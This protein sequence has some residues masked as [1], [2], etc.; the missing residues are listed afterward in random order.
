M[1]RNMKE[2]TD[3]EILRQL[4]EGNSLN[5]R[6]VTDPDIL[7]QL[8]DSPHRK[9]ISLKNSQFDPS[10][11]EKLSPN[12]V[13]GFATL[14]HQIVNS[15]HNISKYISEK[16]LLS[17]KIA[18]M[19]PKQQDY[20][21]SEMMGI[22]GTTADKIVQGS[23]EALPYML[24]P[25]ADLGIL[26]KGIE[27]IPKAGKFLSKSL[28][29]IIPQSN[30]GFALS[31]HP[32][33]GGIQAGLTQAALE[34][35]GLPFKAI[36]GLAQMAHPT[37]Y[38]NNLAKA[39]SENY[40]MAKQKASDL[41]TSVLDRHGDK[42]I[43]PEKSRIYIPGERE[44]ANV[45]QKE[46]DQFKY[47]DLPKKTINKYF[48]P[49]LKKLHDEFIANPSLNN[50]H[51]LQSHLFNEMN[52]LS[53]KPSGSF[54]NNVIQTYN[55]ARNVLNG[56][57]QRSLGRTNKDA[58]NMYNQAREITKNHVVPFRSNPVLN[59]VAKGTVQTIE[60]QR[61]NKALNMAIEKGAIPK[62]HYLNEASK[63]LSDKIAKGKLF[64]DVGSLATGATLGEMMVPGIGGGAAGA[65]MGKFLS[66]TALRITQN[67]IL[68]KTAQNLSLPA[69]LLK[70]A[71]VGYSMNN[72]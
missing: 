41:F 9:P 16:G 2:V 14:G 63:K 7:K 61:L 25:E 10:F 37:N 65:A 38:A 55:Y 44:I 30:V 49:N 69:D 32:G 36:G 31:E 13:S 11:L 39:I 68:G 21:F 72:R 27:S 28:S 42:V 23:V 26:G 54:T 52:K 47:T 46:G 4:N 45:I 6:E 58:L 8:N 19:I 18:D 40:K 5:L 60:P 64:Q 12:I 70:K 34:G 1:V 35:I 53:K 29:R 17:P 71:I 24:A 50:A 22:P 43:Y 57:I 67:P 62:E 51:L 15:P 66:P 20:N 33:E 59:K 56:D 3:P 48:S